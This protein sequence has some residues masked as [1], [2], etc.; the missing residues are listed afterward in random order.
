MNRL[1]NA[2]SHVAVF[3][4]ALPFSGSGASGSCPESAW[5]IRL[6]L[7][8]H[9]RQKLAPSTFCAAHLGQNILSLRSFVGA[10]RRVGLVFN[11]ASLAQR[12][13]EDDA[14]CYRYIK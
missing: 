1:L 8:P 10:L 13:V 11:C 14:G 12:F 7:A 4:Q 3:P 9:T 5:G 2:D 6:T